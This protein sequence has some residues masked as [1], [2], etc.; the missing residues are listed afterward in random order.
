M[1]DA[2]EQLAGLKEKAVEAY[3]G[4]KE[5][6]DEYKESLIDAQLMVLAFAETVVLT[7]AEKNRIRIL[8][9]TGDLERALGLIDIITANGYTPELNAM[10]FRGARALGGPVAGGSTYLVGERGP[11]L[12]TPT[13]SGNIT[14]NNAMGGGNTVTINV[15]G[16]D[17][18]QVVK[19]LQT[20]VR[21]IGP[22]PVNTRTM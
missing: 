2:K 18:M 14:A 13:S 21:T 1:A 5:A 22:V 7:N 15:N 9:D 8:V 4:S 6:V 16:G 3:G 19:A 20:Y 10:R 12:F 17:P 11:E